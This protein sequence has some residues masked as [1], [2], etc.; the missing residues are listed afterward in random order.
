MNSK[1]LI[2]QQYPKAYRAYVLQQK[3]NIMISVYG[4][5]DHETVNDLMTLVDSLDDIESD[6]FI[7]LHNF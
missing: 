5:A 6:K 1:D 2:A 3:V 7:E 4:E